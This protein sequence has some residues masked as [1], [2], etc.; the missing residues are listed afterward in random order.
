MR[1]RESILA[2]EG[3]GFPGATYR[4][5]VLEHAYE[6]AKRNLL[7]AMLA[8]NKA[9]LIMLAEQELVSGEDAREVMKAIIGLGGDE[10]RASSYTGEFE[11]LFFHVEH[12]IHGSAG[13]VAGNLHLARSR[14]DLGV[15]MYRMALR[16][17]LL[18]AEGSLLFLQRSLLS[19]AEEHARTVMPAHTHA[20]RAQPTTLAHYLVA[21]HDSLSRDLRRL[22]AAFDNC[23]RSPLGAAALTTS[24]FDIDRRR[25]AELLAFDGLV[26]NSYDAI[27][28]ADYLGEAAT[29]LQLSFL[30]LGRFVNDLLLWSTQEFGVIRVA[31]PYVQASSIMPQKRNPVSLEH[32]RALLSAGVGDANTVLTMLHN[33]PFGDVVDTEDDLQPYLWRALEAADGLYRLLAVVVGTM[34]V[35]EELLL[36]R[37]KEGH[38]TATELADTLVRERGLAFRTAHAVAAAVVDL[39][40]SQ[41]VEADGVSPA[42]VDRAAEGVIGES[43]G[44]S[45]AQVR[46]ALDPVRFVEV[47]GLPGGPAPEETKRALEGRRNAHA[48]AASV[49]RQR[50][51][52]VNERL[53]ELDALSREWGERA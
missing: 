29:A 36:R 49:H 30:G 9:H 7:D 46:D 50:A 28:G 48:S 47:R 45:A 34:D 11:D 41:G 20:Q 17:R 33:T 53:R 8:A 27:A 5:T 42:L 2:E 32:L 19:V 44:L 21:V 51:E 1:E 26:E 40:A 22:R 31:D 37:A 18:R 14:N 52:A 38:S 35:D 10:I 24:G 4:E 39:A 13:E 15:A 12:L 16:D 43:L 25:L 3:S 6:S 23:N